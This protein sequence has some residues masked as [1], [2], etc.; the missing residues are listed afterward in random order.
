MLKH[1]VCI[2]ADV[3]SY[4]VGWL[5]KDSVAIYLEKIETHQGASNDGIVEICRQFK[6][7]I[8]TEIAK[9]RHRRQ[10]AIFCGYYHNELKSIE[11][12]LRGEGALHSF[13]TP[14]QP[15]LRDLAALIHDGAIAMA[16]ATDRDRIARELRTSDIDNLS[17]EVQCLIMGVRVADSGLHIPPSFERGIVVR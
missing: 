15:N 2:Y 11:E 7:D 5:A 9:Y 3:T 12:R 6:S 16:S 14:E 8:N 17:S 4:S 10:E 1:F 13:P